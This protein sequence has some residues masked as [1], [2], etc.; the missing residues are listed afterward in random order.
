[1]QR[2]ASD[3]SEADAFKS[4]NNGSDIDDDMTPTK[5]AKVN[6]ATKSKG[7]NKIPVKMERK[8]EDDEIFNDNS[9]RNPFGGDAVVEMVDYV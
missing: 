1:M 3:D 5:K 6:P 7:K 8:K 2:D 4:D 9:S